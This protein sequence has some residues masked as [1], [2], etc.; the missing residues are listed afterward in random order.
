MTRVNALYG[1]I[2]EKVL[3]DWMWLD[4][5]CTDQLLTQYNHNMST[6]YFPLIQEKTADLNKYAT[7]SVTAVVKAI[8]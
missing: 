1:E 2:M 3:R 6:I 4:L 7:S 8:L 5:M